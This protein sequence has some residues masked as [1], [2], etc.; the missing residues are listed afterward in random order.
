MTLLALLANI[1]VDKVSPKYCFPVCTFAKSLVTELPPRESLRK[2]VNLESL[3]GICFF[4]FDDSAN[5]LITLH[6]TWR[7]LLMLHPY[8]NL[9]PST[10]V[11]L[12]LS[13]PARSTICNFAFLVFMSYYPVVS[14]ST[15][16]LKITC[17]LELSVFICVDAI[18]LV[19][20]P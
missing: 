10:F 18:F 20:Y 17:D 14:H 3:K 16:M 12:T 13:L 8:L 11:C 6:K 4:F 7:D 19:F 2:C 5:E 9:Y 1:K 15:K